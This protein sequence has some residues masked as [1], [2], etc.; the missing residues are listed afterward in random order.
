MRSK[1]TAALAALTVALGTS[2]G[3]VT[4]LPTAAEAAGPPADIPGVPH[5]FGPYPNWALSPLTTSTAVVTIADAPTGTGTGATASAVIDPVTGGIKSVDL[6]T[7]GSGYANGATATVSG[8]GTG[9]ALTV[10]V[11]PTG[12]VTGFTVDP[13]TGA[14]GGY[15]GF[16][17]LVAPPA[18]GLTATAEGSGGVDAIQIVNGGAGYTMPTVEFDL[19]NDPNGTVAKAHVP[20]ILGGD[21]VDGLDA[22]G[23]VTQIVIDSP[24]SGY[25]TAPTVAVHNGTL[26]DPIAGATPGTFTDD[27]QAAGGHPRSTSAPGTSR[28]LPS[29]CPTWRVGLGAGAVATATYATGGI[30]AITVDPGA[31]GTGYLTKGIKKFQDQLPLTCDPSV[32]TG[33]PTTGK[34]LPVAVP[35]QKPYVDP[36]GVSTTADEIVIGLVQYR[37]QFNTDLPPTL[38]RGYV[39]I[40]TPAQAAFSQ[41]VPLTNELLSGMKVPLTDAA[42]L[43]YYGVTSPQWLGPF[44]NATKDKPVRVVF[45]NLLPTAKDGDLFL[46]VDS[47]MMGSGMGPDGMPPATNDGTVTDGIRNPACTVTGATGKNDMCFKDNR[48]TLHLHGGMS[49]WI[50]DGTP[51]QWITPAGDAGQYPQGVSVQNVPD[52]KDAAGATL[53]EAANDGCS[54]FYY[55]NQQSARLMFYHDHSWGITR[56]NVYAGEAAGYTITDNTE[57]S[58]VSHAARSRT[59]TTRSRWWSRTAPSCPGPP[60]SRPRTRPGTAPVGAA[61]PAACGTTTSTCRLRTPVTPAA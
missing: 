4:L 40:E 61:R 14:G 27:A 50:S 11:N 42:G 25:T 56:L 23:T 51:H 21:L 17:V 19:P 57:K 12:G 39:Q 26:M 52:M 44:I 35:E 1:L 48:A 16:D 60:S 5:Y 45:R 28:R 6:L 58:L 13:L 29:R 34:F 7:P 9:A 31:N 22:N 54:T 2:L 46:P 49:P 47:S 36:K 10:A 30:T 18:A 15:S 38:V 37:T 59:P 33:C 32:G 53:C 43:P 55:T 20:R 8:S 24:G 41:H 3:A